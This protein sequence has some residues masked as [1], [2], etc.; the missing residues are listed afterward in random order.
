MSLFAGAGFAAVHFLSWDWALPV[1][2]LAGFLIAPMIPARGAC[3][4]KTK[5]RD[6]APTESSAQNPP[7]A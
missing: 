7:Q 3:G 1:G 2:L 6:V 4:I 5:P